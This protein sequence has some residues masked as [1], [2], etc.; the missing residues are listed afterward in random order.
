MTISECRE[1]L[2]DKADSMS[3]DEILDYIRQAG[4]LADALLDIASNSLLTHN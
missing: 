4:V 1:I 2:A 3:D